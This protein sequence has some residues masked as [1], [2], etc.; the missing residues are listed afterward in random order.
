MQPD[1]VQITHNDLDGYGASTV[2]GLH[3][4]VSRVEH[5]MRYSD[6]DAIVRPEVD[7]LKG[8]REPALLLCTDV[9]IETGFAGLIRGFARMVAECGVAHR[10]LVIDHH[11]SSVDVLRGRGMVMSEG[12]G[13]L[14]G[15][16]VA[17]PPEARASID[18]RTGTPSIMAV[19]DVTRCATRLAHDLCGL[20]ADPAEDRLVL[21]PSPAVGT[22]VGAIDAADLWRRDAPLF[23]VGEVLNEAFWESVA[24]FVPTGHPMHDPMMSR[25]LLAVARQAAD[26][27]PVGRIEDRLGATR[28]DVVGDL[29]DEAGH[30]PDGDPGTETARMRVSR[31]LATGG[32]LFADMGDGVAVCHAVDP[33]VYQ[34]CSDIMLRQGGA[35]V[36][37]NVMRGGAMS[38]RSRD[39]DGAALALARRFGGGGHAQ[40]AGGR[41]AG[42]PVMSPTDAIRRMREVLSPAAGSGALAAAFAKAKR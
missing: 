28:R 22:L 2:A 20:Y 31:Y 5:V 4:P 32:G 10:L 15:C 9:G 30:V 40:A 8:T 38:F 13:V 7:R 24:T 25:L 11:A 6:V 1:A 19:V 39:E 35:T 14:S 12:E 26:G 23:H 36:A 16:V 42:D 34:R 18:P 3:R 27:E 29:L 33:G 21:E 41:M 37:V 17:V